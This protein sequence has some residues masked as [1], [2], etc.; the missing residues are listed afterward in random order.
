MTKVTLDD[1]EYDSKNFNVEQNKLLSELVQNNNIKTNLE[2]QLS[3]LEVVAGLLMKKLK[4][5]LAEEV[6]DDN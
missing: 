3:S 2:Y 4:K 1:V 6:T 5:S